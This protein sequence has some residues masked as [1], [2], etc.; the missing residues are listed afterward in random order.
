M[1]AK[2]M[3]KCI[4][5]SAEQRASGERDAKMHLFE[6]GA[7]RLRRGERDRRS[8]KQR[9]LAKEMQKCISLSAERRAL[10]KEMQKCISLSAKRRALA[11]EMQKCISLSAK[12]RALAK[13]MQKCI[14]LSAKRRVY[15][16]RD[17]KMHLIEREAA[18]V[19]RKRCR[20]ASL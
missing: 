11:K 2:E 10:A 16:E 19:W 4:S 3:Q 8:A 9:A 15:G 13:E 14:S 7:A 1:L 6:R 17:A 5:L 12:R 20:N 18:R